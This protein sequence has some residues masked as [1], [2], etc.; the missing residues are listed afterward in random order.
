VAAFTSK[1]SGNWSASGQTTWTQVGVPGANDTV[2]IA[3]NITVDVNTTIGLTAFT[4]GGTPAITFTG[5]NLTVNSSVSLT[6]SGDINH[7]A[8]SPVTLASGSTLSFKPPS[9]QTCVW[10]QTSNTNSAITCNGTLGSHVTVKTDLSLGGLNTTSTVGAFRN[11][12]LVTATYTDFSNFGTATVFGLITQIDYN[13][14][15]VSSITNCTFTGCNYSYVS[16]ANNSQDGNF[17]FQFNIFS[18]SVGITVNGLAG[19]C[20]SFAF[21]NN[22]TA[23]VR[24]VDSCS[25]DTNIGNGSL[26][27]CTMSN[28]YFGGQIQHLSGTAWPSDSYW[29]TNFLTSNAT[30]I[31]TLY[32]PIKNSYFFHSAASNPHYLSID[33]TVTAGTLTGL[34][35]ECSATSA[36]GDC[37]FPPTSGGGSTLSVTLCIGI[38]TGGGTGSTCGNIVS[39]LSNSAVAITVEHCTFAS[40]GADG[41]LIGITETT[42]AYTG[43]VASCRGNIVWDLTAGETHSCAVSR[44]GSATNATDA[45]TL[46]GY[47]GFLNPASSPA[48]GNNQC[49][50]NT[51]TSQTGVIGYGGIKSSVNHTFPNTAIGTG[52]IT[53]DPQF[54]DNTRCLAKWGGTVAGGGVATNAAALATLAANPALIGQATTGLLAWVRAGYVPQNQSYQTASYP[55][56][57]STVDAAG[58]TWSGGSPGIG[59]MSFPVSTGSAGPSL[60]IAGINDCSLYAAIDAPKGSPIRQVAAGWV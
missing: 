21:G 58:T 17:T 29:S 47:N 28:N 50:Y 53:A 9:G 56:D 19:C 38:P 55:G 27:Q 31:I 48:S 52:D 59:A 42:A 15:A 6:V 12:G 39:A 11:Q 30:S 40:H 43:E 20:A 2:T 36:D 60:G 46:A 26:R 41:G 45:V 22:R 35:F 25:F 49:F 23:A 51:S 3:H 5:G 18:S 24:L 37:I 4:T 13:N 32:G 54:F 10:N 57:T 44:K 8:D 33:S 14:N 34:I 7:T 1:A 16:S